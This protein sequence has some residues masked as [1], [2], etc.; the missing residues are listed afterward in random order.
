MNKVYIL[1]PEDSK[2]LTGVWN[3]MRAHADAFLSEN[4]CVQITV[5]E[6][7]SF[8]TIEANRYYWGAV[9]KPISEQATVC[10]QKFSVESWHEHF[11]REFLGYD[12]KQFKLP[13][14]REVTTSKV[15]RSTSKLSMKDWKD[16][17]LQCESFATTELGVQFPANPRDYLEN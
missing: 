1:R 7:E 8:R 3:R 6:L 12:F 13:F 14:E 11:K 9:L 10:G 15:L 4:K 2:D 16:Y 5:T 17:I